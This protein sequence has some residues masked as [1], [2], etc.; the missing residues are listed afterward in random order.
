M[1]ADAV[2]IATSAMMAIACQQYR[3]CNNGTCP[4]GVATQKE[5]L[6][7]RLNIDSSAKRLENYFKVVNEELKTFARITG[8]ND[9]HALS[10]EDLCTTS[11]EIS[12]HTNIKHA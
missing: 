1:G 7:S 10:V 2:A 5:E 11:E 3:I 4:V 8:H 6:R 9:I 12:N